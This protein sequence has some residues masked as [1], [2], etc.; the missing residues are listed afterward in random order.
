MY[1]LS[2][3]SSK[4][5]LNWS[6]NEGVYILGRSVDCDLVINDTTVSRK[7][8]RI[9]ISGDKTIMLTDL[10]SH[11]GTVVNGRKISKPLPIHHSDVILLGRIE[12]QVTEKETASTCDGS[13]KITELPGELTY[14]TRLPVE[15]ALRPLPTT[16]IDSPGVLKSISEMGKMLILPG[17][18]EEM[19][20]KALELLRE[21]LPADRLAIFLT[22]ELDNNISL[23]SCW[24]ADKDSSESFSISR[25]ILNDLLRK[26]NAI[27]ISDVQSD[28]K[29]AEQQS[30]VTSSITSVIVVPLLDEGKIWGILYADTISLSKYFTEDY[31]RLTAI[32]GN[33]LA[34]KI[35]HC[36]L[37]KER[38]ARE[39][40][41]SEIKA[42][43]KI[44]EQL[45]PGEIPIIDRYSF[46]AFQ[47]QCRMVGGDLYDISELDG[48]KILFL[49]ADVSGKGIGAALL[50]SNILA[51]F[52]ILYKTRGFNLLEA[53]CSISEQLLSFSR[54][55]D[56]ATL[57]IGILDPQTNKIRYINAGHEPPLIIRKDGNVDFLKA[58]GI[59]IGALDMPTWREEIAELGIGD[60]LFAFTDGITEATNDKG[61]LFGDKSLIKHLTKCQE[62]SPENI[63]GCIMGEIYSFI[64]E[65]PRS[66]DITILIVHRE[67]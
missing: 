51:S 9:E 39:I 19:F 59:P 56:F 46:D 67:R 41:E 66:D 44:Q 35:S 27:L 34:A 12:I 4:K 21:V 8:A 58:S 62:L 53:T 14:A 11:N 23:A 47:I 37:L 31:L 26:K 48:G 5:Q 50:A 6:L 64:G 29:F 43:S 7:H 30:I 20:G 40:L 36:N 3:L 32:F 10:G 38:Q 33:I 61:A 63:T 2:G 54:P 45:L 42:A 1:K 25:T 57:F 13:L 17:P 15:K 28:T 65:T 52:R 22:E 60:F 18:E 49:L 24:V 16:I 55:G